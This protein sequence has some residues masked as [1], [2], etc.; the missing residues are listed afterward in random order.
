MW[1][2]IVEGL[3]DFVY[4]LSCVG[5]GEMGVSLCFKCKQELERVEQICPMCGK[6]NIGGGV[7]KMCSK[8]LGMDGLTAVYAHEERVMSGLIYRVKFEYCRVILEEFVKLLDFEIGKKF[9]MVVPVPLSIYRRNWRGFNQ[10]K[11]IANEV[12]SQLFRPKVEDGRPDL[13]VVECL[14]RVR[15]TKQQSKIKDRKGRLENVRGI[16]EVTGDVKGRNVLLVD[17]VFTSGATMWEATKM[18]KQAG[19]KFVWGLVLARRV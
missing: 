10:A 6:I 13:L 9:D 3:V 14:K 19:A 15:N 4:P 18:L 16:F 11:V 5:C 8:R 1:G 17:D 12:G 7:H 2:K